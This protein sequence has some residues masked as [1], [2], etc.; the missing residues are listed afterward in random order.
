MNFGVLHWSYRDF[1]QVPEELL[2]CREDIVELYLKE[3]FISSIPRWFFERMNQLVFVCLAGNLISSIPEELSLLDNLESLDL[4]QNDVQALP[5]TIGKLTKL[6]RLKLSENKISSLPEEIGL[7][8]KLEILDVSKNLLTELPVELSQCCSLKELA[9]D[10][11]YYLSRIPTKVFIM[12]NLTYL[13]AERCNLILLPFMVNTVSLE[14][15]R[16]FNNYTLTHYPL[17]YEKYMQPNYELFN[18]IHLKRVSKPCCYQRVSCDALPHNLV[19]PEELTRIFDR[20]RSV[21][22]PNSLV[23]ICLRSCNQSKTNDQ[24]LLGNWLP[25]DLFRRL[26]CGPVTT[27]GSI[28]CAKDIFTEGVLG[29]VKRKK[30]A[31]LV[32]FSILFCSKKCSDL[33]FQYNCD[34]YD[35]LNWVLV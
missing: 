9:M 6:T 18:T 15:L 2:S 8:K 30:Q 4:S 14:Y 31:R 16:V 22:V 32:L 29:L 28:P 19:F 27:C 13:S 12:P 7:L 25:A 3:N 10:D 20:R 24:V 11:N 23:E 17:V 21:H 34:V 1:R 33:W 5:K 35:E 26:R